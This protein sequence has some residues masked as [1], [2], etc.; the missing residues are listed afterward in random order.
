MIAAGAWLV[1]AWSAFQA[2][3]ISERHEPYRALGLSRLVNWMG[4]IKYMPPEAAP[5]L[6][7]FA[8]AVGVFFIA[9]IAGIATGVVSA[10]S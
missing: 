7:R 2:W 4:A 1:A 5:H 9:V 3:V 6:A 8:K 10:R